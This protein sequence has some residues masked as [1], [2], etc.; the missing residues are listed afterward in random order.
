MLAIDGQEWRSSTERPL[1]L[2]PDCRSAILARYFFH[3]RDGV[4]ELLDPDGRE[5]DDLDTLRTAVLFTARDLMAG[6]IRNGVMDLRF[7]IDAQD[8]AG[9]IVY[10]LPFHKAVNVIAQV[11]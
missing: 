8:E 10:T 7:R 2:P 9:E 4:D 11:P 3:L 5:F 1:A 6:D